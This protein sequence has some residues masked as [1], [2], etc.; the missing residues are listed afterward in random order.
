MVRPANFDSQWGAILGGGISVA[1]SL[2]SAARIVSATTTTAARIGE[3]ILC[4]TTS[5]G[6]TVTLPT[7]VG[8]AGASIEIKKTSA[9][10]NTLTVATTASQTIDGLT[11]Q[12]WTTQHDALLVTS[13]GANWR[14]T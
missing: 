6:F 5:A 14:V 4:D 2:G 7:A 3:L 8:I 9:D 12:A 11:T 1:S 10:G 13:D